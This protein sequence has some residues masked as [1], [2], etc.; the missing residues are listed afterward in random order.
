MNNDENLRRLDSIVLSDNACE[1]FLNALEED[2]F[3]YYIMNTLPELT[4]CKV[5][6]Q[7]NPWH[8]YDC[9]THILKSVE[10][11][12]LLSKD[13]P[14]DERR[15]L[16]YTM[17]LHDMGK[18]LCKIRQYSTFHKR[19]VDKFPRHNIAG[20]ELAKRS[21]PLLHFDENEQKIITTLVK[22]HDI[23][24]HLRLN[25]NEGGALLTPN[26]VDYL[27]RQYDKLGDGKKILSYLIKVGLADNEAQNKELTENSLKLIYTMGEMVDALEDKTITQTGDLSL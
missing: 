14:A 17:L 26:L 9:L 21:L 13:L 25:P 27:R 19:A 18:P 20:M 1:E 11:M 2:E 16:S 6:S 4:Q 22:D 8:I 3:R 5:T 15:L 23:F 24:I 12:N 7:D 10:N